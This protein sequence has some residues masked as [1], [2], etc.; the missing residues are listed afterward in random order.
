MTKFLRVVSLG[1]WFKPENLLPMPLVDVLIQC[2]RFRCL[3]Q[4]QDG[5][6]NDMHGKFTTAISE[7]QFL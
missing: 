1:G 4:I 2:E 3:G 7:W 5:V 6:W